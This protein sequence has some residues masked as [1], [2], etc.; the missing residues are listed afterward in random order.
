M[1]PFLL[2]PTLVAALAG[3]AAPDDSP[4]R[5]DER[6]RVPPDVRGPIA[7]TVEPAAEP[8]RSTR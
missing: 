8:P 1:R 4:R 2:L 7:A 5:F 3:C 6:S